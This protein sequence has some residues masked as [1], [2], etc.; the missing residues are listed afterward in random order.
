MDVWCFPERK[1]EMRMIR[2]M[3]GVSLKER[4]RRGSSGGCVVF[5]WEKD[6]DEDDQVD[7]CCFIERKTVMRMIRWMCGISLRER[8]MRMIR[9]MCGVSLRERQRRG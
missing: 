1:T 9:W 4:Q 2:W 7:V 3:C 8:Q 5:P 6:R